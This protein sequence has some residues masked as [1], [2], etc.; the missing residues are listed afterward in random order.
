MYTQV[1]RDRLYQRVASQLEELIL[2]GQLKTGDQL[3]PQRELA[4][5]FGVSQPVVREAL[6]VLA[7]RGAIEILPGKGTFV[8]SRTA[9]AVAESLEFLIRRNRRWLTDLLE[10]REHFELAIVRLAAERATPE[11]VARLRTLVERMS[12]GEDDQLALWSH[13]TAFH[14]VLAEATHNRVYVS[15]VSPIAATIQRVRG[16]WLGDIPYTINLHRQIVDAVAHHDP[17]AAVEAMAA[18][19]AYVKQVIGGYLEKENEDIFRG[20]L[21]QRVLQPTKAYAE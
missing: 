12:D 8:A 9:D 20:E 7:V 17:Q 19:M 16:L 11:E 1:S 18:H 13:D 21:E 5:S 10:V 6:R 4:R 14:R 15:L 2:S 3:E